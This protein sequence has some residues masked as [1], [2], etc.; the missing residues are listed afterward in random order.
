MKIFVVGSGKLANTILAS[1]V[2]LQS[3]E[4]VKWESPN[5]TKNEKAILVHAGSGR[6]LKECFEFSSRTKSVLIELSTGLETEKMNPD[7]PLIICPN[8]SILL[9]KTL[10]MLKAYGNS[11]ENYTISI[12]ESHQSTKKTEPGTAFAN[13]LHFPVDKIISIRDQEIQRNEIG[14]PQE[15]LDKHAYHKIVLK[16]GNDEVTIETKV[17]GHDSYANGVKAILETVL[18]NSFEN[19][20]YTVLDLIECKLL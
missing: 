6:Q 15:Y 5:Q 13:A 8:T 2:L 17:L 19:K 3:A 10:V 4:I 12:T 7:F 1:K 20:K 18:S 16:D 14:I 11:F 9:L